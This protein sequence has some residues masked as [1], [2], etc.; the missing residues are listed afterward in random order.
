[1][2]PRKFFTLIELIVVIAIIAVLA[3]IIAPNA[4]RAIEKAKI[5]RAIADFKAIKAA[6]ITLYA[7]TGYWPHGYDSSRRVE[8]SE[9]FRNTGNYAGWDGPYLESNIPMHPWGG[10]YT[11]TSNTDLYSANGSSPNGIH[12]FC[13]EYEDA[14]YPDG[15][16]FKC[17]IP[18]AS[19]KK[20]DEKI[21]DGD[22]STGAFQ[23]SYSEAHPERGDVFWV[24][25]WDFCTP[26]EGA[27]ACW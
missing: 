24:L 9:L 14:C 4:F 16:N 13:L 10:L 12:E 27:R 25:Q 7:D 5:A 8:G 26:E 1:M 17:A 21:D 15:P 20:I 3:A 19:R 22:G 6:S 2:S 23:Y 18:Y 11:F